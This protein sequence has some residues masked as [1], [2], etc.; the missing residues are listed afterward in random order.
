MLTA[1]IGYLRRQQNLTNDMG[2]K[3]RTLAESRWESILKVSSWFKTHR[4]A[5]R[6]YLETKNPSCKPP[7]EWWVVLMF[8]E[9]VTAATTA[10]I[11]QLRKDDTLGSR[12]RQ[13]IPNLRTC[14]K[15]YI[16]ANGPLASGQREDID[17]ERDAV[18]SN[19]FYSA[20]VAYM[21]TFLEY[22]GGFVSDRMQH[23]GQSSM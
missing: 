16:K 8:V 1:L 17:I 7:H 15:D 13:A 9:D 6:E 18:S 21:T 22:M 4:V 5:I 12:Q 3:C 11:K 19:D 23:A 2:T 10:T 14:Y 20:R